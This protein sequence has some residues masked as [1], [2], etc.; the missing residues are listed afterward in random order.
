M[1]VCALYAVYAYSDTLSDA[2]SSDR[3][4]CQGWTMALCSYVHI[5]HGSVY[6]RLDRPHLVA[7]YVTVPLSLSLP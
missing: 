2:A 1:M 7:T 5:A 6:S 4:T 3:S